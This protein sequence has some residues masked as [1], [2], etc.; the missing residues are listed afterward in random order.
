M[1]R[2]I[3]VESV[4]RRFGEQTVLSDIDFFVER[5]EMVALVGPSGCGKTTLLRIIAGLEE[6]DKGRILIGGE[7]MKGV[8]PASRD[9]GMAFQH[10][11]LYPKQ[12]VRRNLSIPLEA[13]TRDRSQ[14]ESSVRDLAKRLSIDQLLDRSV[15]KLSGGEQQRVALG[16]AIIK[17]P[18]VL[19]LDEPLASVDA[20]LRRSLRELILS[21]HAELSSTSIYVT[22]DAHEAA[23]IADRVIVLEEGQIR[24]QGSMAA[25]LA[26]PQTLFI[27]QHASEVPFNLG[28]GE[29]HSTPQG[30][31]VIA[32]GQTINVALSDRTLSLN[33]GQIQFA[34]HPENVALGPN[35][36]GRVE[37]SV[38]EGGVDLL[39]VILD[40]S[41]WWVA[42]QEEMPGRSVSI[43]PKI[44]RAM[45]FDSK[46]RRLP[47]KPEARGS[48]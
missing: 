41:V 21:L 38:R 40:G 16:R 23:S 36:P 48:T 39:R 35:G 15:E 22:H 17:K 24:Q 10:F 34:L 14:V 9:I 18:S 12:T 32:A 47:L 42:N 8:P 26:D 4:S 29:L 28:T 20:A 2:S 45:F 33:P 31:E 37:R 3:Q 6:P 11:A 1:S 43:L 7:N 19:L 44:E 46:G 25:L 13:R 30:W 27:I 5:G